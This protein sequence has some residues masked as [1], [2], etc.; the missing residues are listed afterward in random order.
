LGEWIQAMKELNHFMNKSAEFELLKNLKEEAQKRFMVELKGLFMR[1][2]RLIVRFLGFLVGSTVYGII[3]IVGR[4]FARNPIQWRNR[5]TRGWGQAM[6]R[7]C[8]G[9]IQII[10]MPPKPPFVFVCNHIGYVDVPVLL[11]VLDGVFIAKSEVRS[12]PLLGLLAIAGQ[13][14]FVDRSRRADVVRVNQAIA[15]QLSDQ[16]GL[17]LFPEGTSTDGTH[18]LPFKP[19]LLAYP[20]SRNLPVYF[21]SLT[22]QT[23]HGEMSAHRAIG[24][25]NDD[26][27]FLKHVMR[28]FQIS[29]FSAVLTFG[30]APVIASDRK[31]LA[32]ILQDRVLLQFVPMG[33]Q[34]PFNPL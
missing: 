8:G 5:I 2:I 25:G 22:Y 4:W 34:S 9:R 12:W 3:L 32:Q 21:A 1:W 16:Q 19:S 14:I 33:D 23:P 30:D 17:I 24:W 6:V 11:S 15:D 7:L 26:D 27:V 13:T 20:A 28:F 18:V 29:S 10:G 31:V